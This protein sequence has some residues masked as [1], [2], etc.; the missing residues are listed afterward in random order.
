M[1]VEKAVEMIRAEYEKVKNLEFI[2]NPVAY[3]IYTVWK[4]ADKDYK[5][6]KKPTCKSCAYFD[7]CN[8]DIGG[9][10]SD[11]A[12]DMAYECRSFKWKKERKNGKL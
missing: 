12:N 7:R 3:A 8:D 9:D 5:R 1:N 6:K 11:N 2:R 4:I 10:L